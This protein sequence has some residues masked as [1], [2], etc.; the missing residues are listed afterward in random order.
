[1]PVIRS[2]RLPWLTVEY[3]RVAGA[4][5]GLARTTA[6]AVGVAF[7]GQTEAVWQLGAGRRTERAYAPGSVFLVGGGDLTWNRWASTSEAIE[8]WIDSAWMARAIG[9]PFSWAG[10]EPRMALADPV[11]VSVASM[12]RRL[13]VGGQDDEL[14]LEQLGL[15]AAARIATAHAGLTWPERGRLRPLG[16]RLM[17]RIDGFISAHLEGPIHLHRLA[18]EAAMSPFHF[19]KCFKATTGAAPHQY[20]VARRMDRSM[21][22]LRRTPCTVAEAAAA[23]GYR[24]LGHFRRQFRAHWGQSPG[25]LFDR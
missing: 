9:A 2:L 14:Q 13:L 23:V 21:D 6:G 8:I 1:V 5:D 18:A 17:R 3:D 15:V 11:L 20:V 22:L 25:R 16:D 12:Y 4:R 24:Q 19:A 10:I 7:T